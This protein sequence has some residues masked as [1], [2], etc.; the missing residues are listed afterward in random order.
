MIIELT[1]EILKALNVVLELAYDNILDEN[2][3]KE[4]PELINQRNEQVTACA[5][6]NTLLEQPIDTKQEKYLTDM[7]CPAC[8]DDD[9]AGIFGTFDVETQ[10]RVEVK[11]NVCDATWEDQYRLVGFTDLEGGPEIDFDGPT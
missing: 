2:F 4:D 9:I 1:P 6:V 3:A 7:C 8:G 10:A 5:V 11:C